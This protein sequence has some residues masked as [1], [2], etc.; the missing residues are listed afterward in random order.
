MAGIR[1]Y[2]AESKVITCQFQTLLK[3]V[4]YARGQSPDPD[5]G[6]EWIDFQTNL[7]DELLR[8]HLAQWRTYNSGH[9]NRLEALMAILADGAI[10]RP[11]MDETIILSSSLVE[12]V[13][14]TISMVVK[15]E[16][17]R[18]WA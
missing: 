5:A 8:W 17:N 10:H 14:Q 1:R 6:Q 12:D 2:R 18:A 4:G 15:A 16:R 3:L 11:E 9:M 7:G 13:R